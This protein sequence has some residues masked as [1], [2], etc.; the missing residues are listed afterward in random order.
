[1]A[2]MKPALVRKFV[3]VIAYTI[4]SKEEEKSIHIIEVSRKKADRE[5]WSEK[6]L[7]A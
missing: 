5:S 6:F 7:F 1:M 4:F 2:K 3:K